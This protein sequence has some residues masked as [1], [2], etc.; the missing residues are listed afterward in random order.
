MDLRL[1]DGIEDVTE[2]TIHLP[3]GMDPL[4]SPFNS[5]L[6][7]GWYYQLLWTVIVGSE[8]KE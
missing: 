6:I 4:Q 3:D 7:I 8:V 5:N 2:W 1:M